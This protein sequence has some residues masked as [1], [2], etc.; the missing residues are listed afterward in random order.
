LG[1]TQSALAEASAARGWDDPIQMKGG[2]DAHFTGEIA[3]ALGAW[4]SELFTV[5]PEMEKVEILAKTSLKG[6]VRGS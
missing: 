3:K 2:R 5:S 4:A 6:W 1:F